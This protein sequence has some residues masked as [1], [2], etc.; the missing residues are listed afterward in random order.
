MKICPKCKKQYEIGNFCENCENEDGNPV[1]LEEEKVTCA[2]CGRQYNK[3]TKFCS[4]C[5]VKL[6]QTGS[7][8]N[9]S[10]ISMGDK[11]VIAGDVIGHK[12]TYNVSGNATIVHNEDETKK[13]AKC[14]ICGSIVQRIHGYDCPDCGEFTCE[15]CFD[16]KHGICKNCVENKVK[17]NEENY[18]SKVIEF[19]SDDNRINAEEFK[20]LHEYQEQLGIGDFRAMEIQDEVKSNSRGKVEFT[21]FEKLNFEKAEELF[22][23]EGES[24]EALDLLEPIYKTHPEDEKVLSLYLPV[25]ADNDIEKAKK[26]I[27]EIKTDEIGAYLT[28]IEIAI[29]EKDMATAERRILEAERIWPESV[30]LKCHKVL[31]R[32]ALY[33]QFDSDEWLEKAEELSQ[34]LGEPTNKLE[35]SWQVKVLCMVSEARGEDPLS[36]DREFCKDNGLYYSFMQFSPLLSREQNLRLNEQ[37]R[38]EKERIRR[39]QE[40]KARQELEVAR[41]KALE[42]QEERQNAERQRLEE[43]QRI[44]SLT[45]KEKAIIEDPQKYSIE[46]LIEVEKEFHNA[47]IQFLLCQKYI[48]N[49]QYDLSFMYAE[50]SAN[51]DYPDG[52]AR[53]GWHFLFGRGV[54]ENINKG[55]ELIDLSIS[56]KSFYGQATMGYMYEAG[57]GVSQDYKKAVEWYQKSAEQGNA[58]AQCNLGSMYAAGRGVSQDDKKAVEWYQ[59]SAELGNAVAQCS[60]GLMYQNGLGVIQDYKKAVEW[61]QKSAEQGDANAQFQLGYMYEKGLG[62]VQSYEDAARMYELAVKQGNSDA[63]INLG[64]LYKHG[65]GVHMNFE[66]AARLFRLSAEQGNAYGQGNLG[67][68]YEKGLGVIQSYCDAE[69][70]YQLAINNGN[71]NASEYL[72]D[73][74]FQKNLAKEKK[75]KK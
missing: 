53:L 58:G 38:L 71:D 19:L 41:Q 52:I 20:K 1:R 49:K 23:D 39:E 15:D 56:K 68:M 75:H 43:Q 13:T 10:G 45:R 34:N 60:L 70:W 46:D 62:I 31:Y 51:Q 7:S 8:S 5:G 2:Q 55:K 33:E 24:K 64:L 14:H 40:E 18:R 21:T 4:E 28:A 48:D 63:Q 42:E 72:N 26:I 65:N 17:R 59:K 66:E 27:S 69:Y 30:L 12:E 73:K 25:L 32:L 35:L 67:Y 11:N 54:D 57:R 47:Q 29:R 9:G 50:M 3:G 6:G 44:E 37:K 74:T 16:K 61:Y 36:N 22:Y